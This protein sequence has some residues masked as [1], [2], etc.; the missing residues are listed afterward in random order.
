VREAVR[1]S[2]EE[3]RDIARRLRPEALDDLGLTSALAALTNDVARRAEVRVDRVLTADLPVL[4]DDEELVVYRV[5]QEALTNA[6]RHGGSR[7]AWVQLRAVD[8]AVELEVRDDG[9]GFSTANATTSKP[10]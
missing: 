8:G 2:L 9:A 4:S 6:V 3:V 10:L 5:A 1:G 7:N